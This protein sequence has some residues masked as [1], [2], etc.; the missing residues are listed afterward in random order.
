MYQAG[1]IVEGASFG[2]LL[3]ALDASYCTSGGGDSPT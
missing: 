3:D 1:D 2:N